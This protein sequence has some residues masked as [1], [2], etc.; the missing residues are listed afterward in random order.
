MGNSP[1]VM[2]GGTIANALAKL[3]FR[4]RVKTRRFS[5]ISNNCWGAAAYPTCKIAFQ[6]PFVGLFLVTECY[7]RLL[8]DFHRVME[9]PLRFANTSRYDFLNERREEGALRADYPI[10]LLA[11]DIELHFLHYATPEIAN[12][13]WVRRVA[14]MKEN[15]QERLFVRYGSSDEVLTAEQLSL[16]DALEFAHKVIFVGYPAPRCKSAVYM[17]SSTRR[18]RIPDNLHQEHLIFRNAFFDLAD[19]LNGGTGQPHG[20]YR[21]LMRRFLAPREFRT[22][23]TLEYVVSG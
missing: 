5:L 23:E 10:G 17:P 22:R 16:F 19:W 12:A 18:G 20:A 2:S 9:T 7:F 1:V 13:K 6:S 4:H 11:D 3:W 15:T 8:I 21:L 14:R